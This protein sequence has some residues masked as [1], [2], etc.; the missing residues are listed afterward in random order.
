MQDVTRKLEEDTLHRVN[1]AI[2]RKYLRQLVSPEELRRMQGWK[3][4]QEAEKHLSLPVLGRGHV[5]ERLKICVGKLHEITSH[6]VNQKVVP[7]AERHEFYNTFEWRRARYKVLQDSDGRCQLCG[8][9]KHDG[10]I[11]N[12]DHIKPLKFHWHLR[13]DPNNLQVLCHE[14]NHGKA[15]QDMTDWRQPATNVWNSDMVV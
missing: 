10:I 14:C 8:R 1:N 5:R 7:I 9:G 4:T 6:I 11:L 13:S 2:I 3:L 12:V 15:N